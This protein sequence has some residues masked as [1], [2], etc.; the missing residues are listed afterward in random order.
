MRT[1]ERGSALIIATIVVLVIA[2]I[3]VGMTRFTQRQVAGALAGQR[4]DLVSACAEA[5]RKLLQSRFHALGQ[6]PLEVEVLDVVLDGPSGRVRAVGGHIDADP[7]KPLVE[8]KQVEQDNRMIVDEIRGDDL[9]NR[10][11]DTTGTGGSPYRVMVH[12]QEGDLSSPT[13]GRQLEIEFGVKFGL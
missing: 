13:S 11:V 4:N 7:S 5:A 3:G 8:V 9:S 1:R 10:I 12:C 6:S 2:V